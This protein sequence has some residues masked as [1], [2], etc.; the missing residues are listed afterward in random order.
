MNIT[1]LMAAMHPMMPMMPLVPYQVLY[2]VSQ[3]FGP[4]PPFAAPPATPTPQQG[5][6]MMPYY[7]QYQQSP[8]FWQ[9][10]AGDGKNKIDADVNFILPH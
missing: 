7:M 5:T 4:N 10:G 2:H 1:S 3:Q 9:L 6:M 8:P